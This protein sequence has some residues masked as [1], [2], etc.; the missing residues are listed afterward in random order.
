[1]T[2]EQKAIASWWADAGGAGVGVPAP[3]HVLSIITWVLENQKA[4]LG[5]AV[6]VYAKTGI[7]QKDAP[8][9]TF[10]AKFQYNLIRPVNLCQT[11]Y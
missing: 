3:H 6:E 9:N 1:M 2:E 5:K 4:K 7:V 11:A 10:R 8:I